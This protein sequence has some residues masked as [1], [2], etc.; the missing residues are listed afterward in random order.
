MR[1]FRL[2]ILCLMGFLESAG[3]KWTSGEK[4]YRMVKKDEFQWKMS[5]PNAVVSYFILLCFASAEIS[6]NVLEDYRLPKTVVPSNYILRIQIE[7]FEG[8]S[9]TG[10]VVINFV[11]T[12][13]NN[14]IF[15]HASSS[16]MNLTSIVLN[17]D[18]DKECN[19]TNA[20]PNTDILTITCKEKTVLDAMNTLIIHYEALFSMDGVGLYKST[21]VENDIEEIILATQFSPCYARRVFPCFDEPEF[22]AA[23]DVFLKH[24]ST[25]H[26]LGN[27]PILSEMKDIDNMIEIEFAQTPI[28]PTHLLGFL[29]SKFEPGS[30]NATYNVFTRPEMRKYTG[31]ALKYT[32]HLVRTMG[33]WIGIKYEDMENTQLFQIALEH[34]KFDYLKTWGLI[35]YRE[36][37]ILDGTNETTELTK[38][39][40]ILNMAHAIFQQWFG[41]Y[42]T[43]DWWSNTWLT[44]GFATYFEYTLPDQITDLNFQTEEQFNVN[45]LQVAL[46]EDSHPDSTPLSSREED[47]NTLDDYLRKFNI[48]TSAKGASLIRMMR[49]VL[50]EEEFKDG[51]KAYLAKNKFN[52]TNPTSL[53]ESLNLGNLMEQ[54]IY[55]PGYPLLTVTRQNKE[56][57]VT[58]TQEEFRL[59]EAE[60]RTK[61]TWNVPVT[62]ATSENFNVMK[63]VWLE[64]DNVLSITLDA[65]SWIVLDIQQ[66][67]FYRVNYDEGLWDSIIDALKGS[68]R[69]DIHV[70]NRA[71][72]I[73]DIFNIAL[74]GKVSYEKVFELAAY[75]K[76]EIEYEP[77]VSALTA[78]S[79]LMDHINDS[80]TTKMVKVV[81]L[82]W[83]NH[84][85]P[86]L[87]RIGATSHIEVLKQ[88]LILKWK[89]ELQSPDCLEN[90]AGN[91]RDYKESNSIPNHEERRMILCYGAKMSKTPQ[92]EYSFLINIFEDAHSPTEQEDILSAL[93][94]IPDA[95]ILS[96][97]L[98]EIVAEQS[99]ISRSQALIVFRAVYSNTDQGIDVALDFLEQNMELIIEK[100]GRIFTANAFVTGLDEKIRTK[101]QLEK[102]E[103]I[104]ISSAHIDGVYGNQT[105]NRIKFNLE[106]SE[107]YTKA[108][109]S[110]LLTTSGGSAVKSNYT[111]FFF[112]FVLT[113]IYLYVTK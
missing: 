21:Y 18:F 65:D 80:E 85:F 34:V 63:T 13:A 30:G 10:S 76:H 52:T 47:I 72:L 110:G 46:R 101:E 27:T 105:I 4:F 108:I 103:K 113:M 64:K 48:V 84:A 53:L 68:G 39:K 14:N 57:K 45:I 104:I 109:K 86:G 31:T 40:I 60:K 71:Q 107:K 41:A 93:G 92:D 44:E 16:Y 83:I 58:V 19:I 88:S 56:A 55:Q 102:F 22:K 100:Y 95:N 75:L 12:E 106:W 49:G 111:L 9:F 35:S 98:L 37:N 87:E 61:T 11:T 38:Q 59:V 67:G 66:M 20:D 78:I 73:D 28:M 1:I 70:L 94:C 112:Q 5:L 90:S 17:A 82:D 51:L 26:A 97:Y 23:F 15:L 24:P 50:G 2:S 8:N 96:N 54:W 74:T 77:W 69:D 89:C 33:D 7:S 81:T 79:Y 3:N 25:H 36:K 43:L 99:V 32:P 62:F 29:I 91:F 42:V 6:V